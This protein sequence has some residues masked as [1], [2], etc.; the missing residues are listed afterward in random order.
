MLARWDAALKAG[1]CP[2]C[3]MVGEAVRDYLAHVLREGK[4]REEVYRRIRDAAGFCEAHTE[5]LVSLGAESLGD[6][7]SLLR[8]YSW[9]VADLATGSSPGASCA[10]CETAADYEGACLA[11]LRDFVHPTSGDPELRRQYADGPG[12]CRAHFVAAASRVAENASLQFLAEV[13]ARSWAALSRDLKEYLRKH[14]YRFRHEPKTAEEETSWIRAV[15]TISGTP[16]GAT[17]GES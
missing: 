2:V 10:A 7:R 16:F 12:L 17:A 9:L 5:V 1:G 15:A 8:L 6:R 4:A 11:A 13:Q 3:R 14:D